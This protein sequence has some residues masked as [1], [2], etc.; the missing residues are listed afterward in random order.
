[1]PLSEKA[2]KIIDRIRSIVKKEEDG[3]TFWYETWVPGIFEMVV[4][5]E[6]EVIVTTETTTTKKS[7][8]TTTTTTTTV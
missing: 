8:R 4:N 6:E 7:R 1:M 5:N 3:D 2:Q